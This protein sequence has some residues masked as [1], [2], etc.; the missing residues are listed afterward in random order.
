MVKKLPANAGDR[1][2]GFDP[3]VGK[4]GEENDDS[5]EY[6]CLGKPIDKRNM[7]DYSPWGCKESDTTE[8]THTHI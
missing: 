3:W 6:S 8:H 4:I 1:R 5:L 2:L 7:V